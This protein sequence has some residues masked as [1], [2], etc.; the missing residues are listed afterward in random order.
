MLE[1]FRIHFVYVVRRE[2]LSLCEE[3]TTADATSVS[4]GFEPAITH[5]QVPSSSYHCARGAKS[6]A[7][8]TNQVSTTV[9]CAKWRLYLVYT[10]QGTWYITL[11]L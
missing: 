5:M 1:L 7:R 6:C 4:T 9:K 10:N 2:E 3:L 8:F 11:V